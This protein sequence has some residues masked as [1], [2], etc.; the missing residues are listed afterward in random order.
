MTTGGYV[1]PLI[2]QELLEERFG[3]RR[4]IWRE[5]R[6]IKLTPEQRTHRRV[7]LGLE[8]ENGVQ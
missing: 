2:L 6:H 3:P 1:W 5:R 8:D 4:T 7:L